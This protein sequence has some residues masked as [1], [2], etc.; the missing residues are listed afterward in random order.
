MG[1]GG[2]ILGGSL[3]ARRE[4]QAQKEGERGRICVLWCG[5]YLGVSVLGLSHKTPLTVWSKEQGFNSQSLGP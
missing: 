2:A 5:L 1:V 3:N 4:G